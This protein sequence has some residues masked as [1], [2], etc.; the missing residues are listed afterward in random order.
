MCL[1]ACVCVRRMSTGT[2]FCRCYTSRQQRLTTREIQVAKREIGM[3][4]SA[5]PLRNERRRRFFRSGFQTL[6]FLLSR[7]CARG[8]NNKKVNSWP[9]VISLW[10]RAFIHRPAHSGVTGFFIAT[11]LWKKLL[12]CLLR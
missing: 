6:S 4:L 9:V 11:A 5:F 3:Q 12:S 2:I 8:L 10:C 1:C 7:P